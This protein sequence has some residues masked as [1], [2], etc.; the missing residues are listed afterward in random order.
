MEKI[1]KLIKFA[2]ERYESTMLH[3]NSKL[4][5]SEKGKQ[6]WSLDKDLCFTDKE[7][8]KIKKS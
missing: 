8:G 3:K 1:L 5:I 7:W 2:L 6:T 4:V